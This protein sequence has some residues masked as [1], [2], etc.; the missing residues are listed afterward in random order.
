MLDFICWSNL[1]ETRSR[2]KRFLFVFALCDIT[3]GIFCAIQMHFVASIS[4]FDMLDKMKDFWGINWLSRD[5]KLLKVLNKVYFAQCG[6]FKG[7][8]RTAKKTYMNTE[9][10]RSKYTSALVPSCFLVPLCVWLTHLQTW[11][12][13]RA[14]GKK[15]KF[16]PTNHFLVRWFHNKKKTERD[17]SHCSS[18]L[19]FTHTH[20]CT[21]SCLLLGMGAVKGEQMKRSDSL[22]VVT[23]ALLQFS[24]LSYWGQ[25]RFKCEQFSPKREHHVSDSLTVHPELWT[26]DGVISPSAP[27]CLRP[28]YSLLPLPR[29]LCRSARR[30]CSHIP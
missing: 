5:S 13:L 16:P 1:E 30:W 11:H 10:C 9:L 29:C 8:E 12:I 23:L 3:R 21:C 25:S 19:A 7:K 4:H 18:I 20:T 22:P 24:F 28:F 6:S 27:P 15:R 26:S 14:S 2:N 17:T